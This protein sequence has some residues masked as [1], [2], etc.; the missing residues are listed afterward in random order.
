MDRRNSDRVKPVKQ[1][2]FTLRIYDLTFDVR[3][4]NISAGGIFL[5]SGM[6]LDV[7]WVLKIKLSHADTSATSL[8]RVCHRHGYRVGLEF[9][10]PSERF[11]KLLKA[12][13][14]GNHWCTQAMA[15]MGP[16][17]KEVL[18]LLR[19]YFRIR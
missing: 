13:L 1:Q 18:M 8:A 12:S 19:F 10:N 3:P 4:I 15:M 16:K 7:G 5:T 6:L 17:Y 14:G 11:C 9:V 2:Q